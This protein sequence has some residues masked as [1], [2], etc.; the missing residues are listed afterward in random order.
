MT[1]PPLDRSSSR[2][3]LVLGGLAGLT[4]TLALNGCSPP[5]VAGA[6]TGTDGQDL[7]DRV[8]SLGVDPV[9]E[10]EPAAPATK[11]VTLRMRLSARTEAGEL[12]LGPQEIPVTIARRPR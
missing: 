4:G 11:S 8:I 6:S 2:R 12:D 9:I 3:T 1:T 7:R 5:L 10:L